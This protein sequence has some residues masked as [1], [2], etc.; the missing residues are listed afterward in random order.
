MKRIKTIGL[1]VLAL[2][3]GQAELTAAQTGQTGSAAANLMQQAQAAINTEEYVRAVQILTR[4]VGMPENAYS[5]PALELLGNVREANG[6]LAHAVAEYETYLTKYPRTDG[7]ARVQQRLNALVS[8]AAPLA[9][10]P[11]ATTA[12]VVAAG[13]ADAPQAPAAAPTTPAA[14]PA[15]PATAAQVAA[16]AD[17]ASTGTRVRSRGVL[18]LTYRYNEGATEITDLTPDPDDA[19]EEED[20]FENAL[21]A[22]LNYQR[23]IDQ[24]DQRITLSFSGLLEFDFESDDTDTEL[25]LSEA[26]VAFEDRTTG[27][28]LTAGRQ[29]VEPRGIAYRTD[30]VSLRWPAGTGVALGVVAGTVVESSR[31]DFL[32]GDRYLLGGGAEFEGAALGGDIA[33]YAA[34]E[35]DGSLTY[36]NVIGVEFDRSVEQNALYVNL[37][38][39]THFEEVSR[40]LVTGT[41]VLDNAA[42]VTGRLSYYRNPSLNLENALIGQ[43]AE[44][45][46]ELIALLGEDSVTAL[47]L[48]RSAKVTTLGMTYYGKLGESWDLSLDGT[49]YQNSGTPATTDGT[50]V[51][52][53]PDAGVQGYYGV[54]FTGES[55]FRPD[56]RLNLGLRYADN[57]DSDL[58]V[59]D[60]SFRIPLSADMHLTPRLRIGQQDF[61]DGSD[62]VFAIPSVSFRYKVNPAT[63]LQ[64]DAGGRWSRT[65]AESTTTR[66]HEFYIVAGVSRSF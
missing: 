8:G 3:L 48:D 20:T 9:P 13:G 24:G 27:R 57:I 22:G 66:Q 1:V 53:V 62:E 58:I 56:D 32:S 54:R 60:G 7:A 15:A 33:V 37:E 55:I 29:R 38:Y 61:D 41:T 42:R 43:D 50:P 39:D 52:E 34:M 63:S 36:R 23:I 30:G 51:D 47:A 16:K 28:V 14:A 45:I 12:P 18:T 10:N 46:D 35:R 21:V 26:L 25:R 59:A 65:E 5:A 40:F 64:V 6:Q 19:V 17:E 49:L 31:D 2:Q 11:P 4:I 44:T